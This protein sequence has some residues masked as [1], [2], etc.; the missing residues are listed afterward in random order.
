MPSTKSGSF[1]GSGST[2]NQAVS[3][4]GFQPEFLILMT[5][6]QG[7][8][9]AASGARLCMG[10]AS[11]ASDQQAFDFRDANA[12]TTTN[13][14][15][16]QQSGKILSIVALT[17]DTVSVSASL[18]S[19]DSD[20]F[21]INWDNAAAIV[22]H[23][24]AV[25]GADFQAKVGSFDMNGSTGNQAVTGVGFQPK[26]VMF[27]GTIDNTTEGAAAVAKLTMGAA[28]SASERW[29]TAQYDGDGHGASNSEAHEYI[30][31][32]ACIVRISDAA[33][34]LE[35]D[36]VS[37]D[38]DG[39]TIDITTA[40]ACR[41]IY[42]AFGGST[43]YHAGTV[44]QP[45]S[46]GTVVEENIDLEPDGVLFA[47]VGAAS[48]DTIADDCYPTF[49]CCDSSLQEECVAAS[50][51]DN[52]GTSDSH[53]DQASGACIERLSATANT[54]VT[55][56]SMESLDVNGFTLN[57]TAVDSTASIIGYLAF[58]TAFNPGGG[59]GSGGW[60]WAG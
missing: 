45:T 58:G 48:L 4:I 38:A 19:F 60:M 24:F 52:V 28:T 13:T 18:V 6:S 29:A 8:D 30:T 57:W 3:G 10:V 34:T 31:E 59:G 23:Y 55:Q 46:T 12:Q 9:G 27:F 11:S 42:V 41:M 20:G 40:L 15:R 22:V 36:F 35:A 2:G 53:R 21:T 49:G 56:A 25:A 37:L 17:T 47:G 44:V 14:A 43:S 5:D 51:N 39:F 54:V 32:S 7:D 16:S 50:V 1:T 26:A 33:V